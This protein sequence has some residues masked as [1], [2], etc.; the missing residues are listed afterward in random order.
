MTGVNERND[1]N[2]VYGALMCWELHRMLC[3]YCHLFFPAR[4]SILVPLWM[5]MGNVI[6]CL[7]VGLGP[8]LAT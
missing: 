5:T 2:S 7:V 4:I 6:G 1:N 3:M 8:S